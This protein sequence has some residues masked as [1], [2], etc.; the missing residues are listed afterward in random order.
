MTDP[1]IEHGTVRGYNHSGC[2]CE[3]CR[4]AWARY[5]AADEAS[6]RRP[7]TI[8]AKRLPRD[9]GSRE[10]CATHAGYEQHKGLDEEACDA[11]LDAELRYRRERRRKGLL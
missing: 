6:R 11:C 4:A 9:T 5:S 10:P 2:R 1:G 8:P 3:L 7:G